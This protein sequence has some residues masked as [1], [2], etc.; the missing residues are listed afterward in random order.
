VRQNDFSFIVSSNNFFHLQNYADFLPM[1]RGSSACSN[2]PGYVRVF[3]PKAC[4]SFWKILLISL[5]AWQ[6]RT[7][8]P[9]VA[10]VSSTGNIHSEGKVR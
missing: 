3:T 9:S 2:S 1:D 7:V 8:G 5:P 4:Y 6:G 10:W